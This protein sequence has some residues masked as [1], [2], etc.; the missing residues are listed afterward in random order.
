MSV[1]QQLINCGAEET[2][3][4]SSV[5]QLLKEIN[6]QVTPFNP[7]RV[8]A[9]KSAGYT[10]AEICAVFN[11]TAGMVQKCTSTRLDKALRKS[12]RELAA[13]KCFDEGTI[14]GKLH[15]LQK[16][17][18]SQKAAGS[19]AP[20]N[21]FWV[22]LKSLHRSGMALSEVCTE[23]NLSMSDLKTHGVC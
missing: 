10:V 21:D 23:F 5:P 18:A 15:K 2:Q 8:R 3:L 4:E 16:S 6:A 17:L 11:I 13:T 9:M 22:L 14:V 12:D 7:T 20:V 1:R 19:S